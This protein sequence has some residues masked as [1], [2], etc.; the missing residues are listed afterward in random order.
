MGFEL[1]LTVSA[2]KQED[3]SREPFLYFSLYSPELFLGNSLILSGNPAVLE[4]LCQGPA[5]D[6]FK[7][8]FKEK[9]QRGS[10]L[11]LTGRK[12]L[13]NN[14]EQ[15]HPLFERGYSLTIKGATF[16]GHP[17]TRWNNQIIYLCA[18]ESIIK[19]LD[20]IFPVLAE[21]DLVIKRRRS[22]RK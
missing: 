9:N 4:Q 14:T 12:R 21:F 13:K 6:F 2:N 16:N 5:Y 17:S 8:E 3:I 19:T 18:D 10:F 20:L 22:R 7:F 11:S 1:K 15:L